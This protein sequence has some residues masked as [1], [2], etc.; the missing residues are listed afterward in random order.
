M[1][2]GR[3]SRDV[4]QGPFRETRNPRHRV[5]FV[6]K[7][8]NSFWRRWT[9]DVLPLLVQRRK[10]DVHRRNVRVDDIVMMVGAN[11]VRGKWILGRVVQVYPGSDGNV[12]NLRV[13]TSATEFRRPVTKIAVMYPAEDYEDD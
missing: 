13:K 10:W 8:V 9:R 11:A 4:P 6:K 12:R 3:A 2:P 1:L 7:I 5:E